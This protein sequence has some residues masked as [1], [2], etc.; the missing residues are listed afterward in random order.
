MSNLS[1]QDVQL[2]QLMFVSSA[3]QQH[4]LGTRGYTNDGRAFRY[5]KAGGADLA[6]GQVLQSPAI[7]PGHL[8]LALATSVGATTIGSIQV[9]ATCPSLMAANVY[10]EGFLQISAG[11]G[12]GYNYQISSHAAV[13]AGAT[14]T[15]NLYPEDALVV[16]LG[17]TTIVALIANKYN[18]VIQ[19]PV[20]TATGV[21]VGVAAYVI[22]QTQYGWIQTWGDCPVL[23]SGAGALGDPLVGV[24]ATAGGAATATAAS[25]L[26][27]P[28]IGYLRQISVDTKYNSVDLK[29]S[30]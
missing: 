13:S 26:I 27:N 11:V 14:G 22:T 2:A 7:T 17:T 29:V 24:S 15:F 30:P 19:M 8:A 21:C 20:T 4:P 16:A 23:M 3:T 5:A 6:A 12:Q 1:N 28:V 9:A 25:L 18:G 10:A